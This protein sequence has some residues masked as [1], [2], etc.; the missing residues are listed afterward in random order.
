MSRTPLGSLFDQV[1]DTML[2]TTFVFLGIEGA[3]V[4]SRLASKRE[5]VGRATLLG[6]LSVL[7]LF[8]SVTM[9]SY[10]VMPRSDLASAMQPSMGSVLESVVGPGGDTFVSIGVIISVQGAYLAWTL[11]N[12][13]VLYMPATTEVMPRFLT[14]N[15][16]EHAPRSRRCSPRPLRSRSLLLL[17]LFV[18]DA[19][20]FMLKL[21]TALALIPYLL[22]AAYALK[23]TITRETYED[24]DEPERRKQRV[25]AVAAVVYA[26]FLLY[27][28]GA[29]Y[30]LARLAS[31]TH[32]A[33]CSSPAM[34]RREQRTPCVHSP[35]G[36]GLCVAVDRSCRWDRR[37]LD[38]LRAH[39][40]GEAVRA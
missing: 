14:R 24:D 33:R 39:L 11:I 34:A 25:I 16:A 21:D 36:S 13:E 3:S 5:D 23:L 4:Y 20:N 28:A 18:D 27:S 2:I 7:A 26:V 10:G 12:A 19:L 29:E 32:R 1:K 17:V 22:A 8:A 40:T 9:V 31:S 15:N 30:L 38:R 35:G 37:H 6:F